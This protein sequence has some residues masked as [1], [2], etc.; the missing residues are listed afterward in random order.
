MPKFKII[1]KK[2]VYK[3]EKVQVDTE[4]ISL[5]NGNIVEWDVMVNPNFLKAVP[6]K[7]DRVLMTKEWRQGPH[8]YLTQFTG[9]RASLNREEDNLK[10]LKREM[11]EE[12]GIVGGKYEKIITFQQGVRLT[13]K[14]TIYFVTNFKSRKACPEKNE[15][16]NKI[17]LP[18][19][20]LFE[21]LRDHH[22][23]TAETLLIAKI[24]QEK[25]SKMGT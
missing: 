25:Y 21:E 8:D 23:V 9:S 14:Q 24:L 20:G 3:S 2:T 4:T 5:P 1:S 13:G 15:I 22:I 11:K 18:I 12:L 16:Q 7:N 19:E 10:E 17:E 6:I